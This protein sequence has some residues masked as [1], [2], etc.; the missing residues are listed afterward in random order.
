MCDFQKLAFPEHGYIVCC[1]R[2]WLFAIR[3][4]TT[5]LTLNT[6]DFNALYNSVMLQFNNI[7][8]KEDIFSEETKGICIATP[9]A[10]CSF[11]FTKKELQCFYDMLDKADNEIKALYMLQLFYNDNF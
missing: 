9:S 8:K 4:G 5:M 1:Y 3:V 11:I 7:S 6:K 2:M 10:S